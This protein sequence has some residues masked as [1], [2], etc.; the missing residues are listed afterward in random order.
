MTHLPYI[1]AAYGLTLVV[2]VVFSVDAWRRAASA[3]R[4]LAALDRRGER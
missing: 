1:A 4:R 2:V 3:R